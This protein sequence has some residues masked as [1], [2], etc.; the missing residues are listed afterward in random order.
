MT[1]NATERLQSGPSQAIRQDKPVKATE[2]E[3]Q[4]WI[5]ENRDAFRAYDAMVEKF[6]LFGDG[7]RLF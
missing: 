6:G 5:E 1:T 2:S 4:R 3:K 7:H